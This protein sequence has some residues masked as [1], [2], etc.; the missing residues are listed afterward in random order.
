MD[1]GMNVETRLSERLEAAFNHA[2]KAIVRA[3][4]MSGY[5]QV[6]RRGCKG[7]DGEKKV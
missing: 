1:G 6:G 4:G 3:N 2:N 5:C 7:N